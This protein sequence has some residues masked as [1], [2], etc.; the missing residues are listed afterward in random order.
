MAGVSRAMTWVWRAGTEE[1]P[2]S[3]ESSKRGTSGILIISEMNPL[4]KDL[5]SL[6]LILVLPLVSSP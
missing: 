2:T 5:T 6:N 4:S 1:E 3:Y